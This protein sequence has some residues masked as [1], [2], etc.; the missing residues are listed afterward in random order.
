MWR[1]QN[2]MCGQYRN[3]GLEQRFDCAN[4]FTYQRSEHACPILLNFV[5]PCATMPVPAILLE[6]YQVMVM[7]SI[8]GSRYRT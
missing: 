1:L 6:L 3:T 2:R 5:R 8:L 4:A 7:E